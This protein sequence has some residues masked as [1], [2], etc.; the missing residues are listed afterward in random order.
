[1]RERL[2]GP[3]VGLVLAAGVA[4]GAQ[5]ALTNADV[6]KLET[7]ATAFDTSVDGLVALSK[8]GI[9]DGVIA[10]MVQSEAPSASVVA[11]EAQP[12]DFGDDE[13]VWANDGECDDFR[14]HC[15][16][17]SDT[18][19]DEDR[20]HDATDCRELFESGRISL[21]DDEAAM[22][23]ADIVRLTQAGIGEAA[24]VNV[25]GSSATDFDTTVDSLVA[26][27]EA[28]VGD[29]VIAAMAAAGRSRTAAQPVGTCVGDECGRGGFRFG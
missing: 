6:V 18:L 10:A 7:S 23:N 24:V 29:A 12:I 14:F 4:F 27:A 15:D 22:T 19:L 5:D 17:M 11:V 25:I 28:G 21:M 3:V 9:G 20:G 26:P 1:M 13:S 2:A 16:G 8:A